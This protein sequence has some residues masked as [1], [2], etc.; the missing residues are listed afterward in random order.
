ME[1][2]LTVTPQMVAL[3]PSDE[4]DWARAVGAFVRR[5]TSA[6]LVVQMAAVERFYT[7]AQAATSLGVSKA[8][9]HRRILDGTI[10]ASQNGTRYRIREAEVDAYRNFLMRQAA[11]ATA[12]DF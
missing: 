9:V 8:T 7:P 3:N 10:N 11:E 1:D 5:A 12:N 6:G 2:T 4:S